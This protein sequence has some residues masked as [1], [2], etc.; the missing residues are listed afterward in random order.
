MGWEVGRRKNYKEPKEGD[1]YV[2]IL[3]IV[4]ASYVKNY[5]IITSNIC[6]S[7][8]LN[9]NKAVKNKQN[10]LYFFK[11]GMGLWSSEFLPTWNRFLGLA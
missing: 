10:H 6:S 7:F 2:H 5:Q 9:L 1:I 4:M 3:V 8:H 11:K